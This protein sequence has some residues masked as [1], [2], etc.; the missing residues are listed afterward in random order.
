MR[1]WGHIATLLEE[2][3]TCAM[4]TVAEAAGSTPREAG[5]RMVVREDGAFFGT[6]GGGT[7][8]FEALK[9]AR[10]ALASRVPGH[11]V[12]SFSLGPD[13]GQCCG[14]RARIMIEVLQVPQLDLAR[15][16]ARREETGE[17]FATRA[18]LSAGRPV[19]R[20]VVE[21]S[22]RRPAVSFED[23]TVIETFGALRRPLYLF[24]A[25]HVG[26]AV[27]L[28]LAPLPFDVVWIDSRPEVF[29]AAVPSNTRMVSGP[30]PAEVLGEAPKES[31]V[32]VMTHSHALDEEIVAAALVQ[33]RF[34]YVGLIGSQT[35]KTRF[36]RRLKM[37]GITANAVNG[38]ICPVGSREIA[39]K[40]P[41]A[42]AAGVAVEVLIAHEKCMVKNSTPLAEAAGSVQ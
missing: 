36:E 3:G 16:L 8:E 31:F 21:T 18:D 37:R 1:V 32:L 42:I 17:R 35:K 27:V 4:V 9:W 24:G 39:S 23:D 34:P 5:A 15:T 28:A 7:L 13:L 33:Q 2:Q 22:A 14:G 11:S 19:E 25:G 41:A 12:R 30:A 29:P 20:Q 10:D 26:K 40:A 6:I 38:L